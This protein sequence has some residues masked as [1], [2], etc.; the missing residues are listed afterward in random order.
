LLDTHPHSDKKIYR[1]TL[2]RLQ[3]LDVEIIHAGHE[4]SFSNT[5]MQN[6]IKEYLTGNNAMSDPITWF[7]NVSKYGVDH[8]SN[9]QW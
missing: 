7:N 3:K 1:K 5:K 2:E 6:I 8:Y 9:Q 4:P